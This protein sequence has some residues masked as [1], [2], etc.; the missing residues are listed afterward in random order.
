MKS[1]IK[2]LLIAVLAFLPIV[3]AGVVTPTVSGMAVSDLLDQ[4][5]DIVDKTLGNAENTGSAL[6]ANSANQLQVAIEIARIN[7]GSEINKTVGSLKEEHRLAFQRLHDLSKEV[8][9]F[10]GKIYELKD[11]TVLDIRALIKDFPII[12]GENYFVQSVSGLSQLRKPD[13][14]TITINGTGFGTSSEKYRSSIKLFKAGREITSDLYSVQED[15][16]NQ[17]K[18]LMDSGIFQNSDEKIIFEKISLKI[19]IQQ[20]KQVLGFLWSYWSESEYNLPL[21]MSIFPPVAGTI[22]VNSNEQLY[23]W[24]KI[25]RHTFS[26]TGGNNHCSK[27]CKKHVGTHYDRCYSV[28]GGNQT[29]VGYKRITNVSGLSCSGTC[30]YDEDKAKRL[31]GNSS[32]VCMHWR[33]RSHPSTYS[34]SFDIEEYKKTGEKPYSPQKL[35]VQYG[36]IIEVKVPL[37]LAGGTIK[38]KAITGQD[39]T[40]TISGVH[41]NPLFQLV[42]KRQNGSNTIL[43]LKIISAPISS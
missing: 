13:R 42:E 27:N 30:G 18:V 24:V 12:D 39:F 22:E 8:E 40:E 41:S 11:S 1:S 36:D 26:E 37:K 29:V 16:A 21:I 25:T 20:K 19:K 4:A 10:E 33:G 34:V 7:F 35:T 23:G 14:Y 9:S 6:I 31:V 28:T 32:K 17:S 38:G 3:Y 43:V 2:Y 5:E 15:R